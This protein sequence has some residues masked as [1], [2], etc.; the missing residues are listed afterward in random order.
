MR[1]A[2]VRLSGV[3][4]AFG[5]LKALDAL[6]L[7]V[8]AGHIHAVIGPNGA[9]KSTLFNVVSGI[10]P[11]RSGRVLLDDTELQG[12]RPHRIARLGVGR[13]FQN[14]AS[15]GE[16]TVL[17]SLMVGRH[18]LMRHG[19][20]A[21]M[22]GWPAARR[23]ER[24]HRDRVEEIAAFTGI[25]DDLQRRLTTLPY[26][27]KKIA[28]VTR[29]ICMEPRLLLLDEPAAGLDSTETADM[30][31][32]IVALRDGLGITVIVI[33]HDMG[34]VMAISDR[35]TVLDFGRR[36][37]DG[38]PDQVRADPAVADAYLGTGEKDAA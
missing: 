18:D 6:D 31:R 26:G 11:V 14:V 8:H 22:T 29:A 1:G 24:R 32:L 23:E 20:I 30:A 27:R 4:V 35:V 37:S 17:E 5:A 25:G 2:R 9:G 21:A 13:A 16:E 7:D 36:I 3:T 19:A 12:L 33:E 34:L 10:Y 15:R 28:D 38:T